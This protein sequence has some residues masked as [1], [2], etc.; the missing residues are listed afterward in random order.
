LG[1][2]GRVA[3]LAERAGAAMGLSPEQRTALR[4]AGLLH[5]LG[6]AGV[7]TGVWDRPGPLTVADWEQVRLHAY[8]TERIL[9]RTPALQPLARIARMHHESIEASGYYRQAS[10][11][12]QTAAAR[13]LAAADVCAALTEDRPHRNAFG[14]DQAA[15]LMQKEPLDPQAVAA[16][17]EA[18]GHARK[19]RA[20]WPA[21]LTDREVEV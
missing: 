19:V 12:E 6:R 17:L 21:G 5:D 4:R 8:H 18:A 1:H 16:V 7:P 15:P 10:P 9:S 3:E 2:S 14:L 11:G 13:V 20:S